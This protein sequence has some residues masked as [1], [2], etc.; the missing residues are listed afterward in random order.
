MF[1]ENSNIL[2][3]VYLKMFEEIYMT[4]PIS[5]SSY[6]HSMQTKSQIEKIFSSRI[7]SEKVQ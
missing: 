2:I 3:H 4:C 7:F 5:K 1:K 6:G